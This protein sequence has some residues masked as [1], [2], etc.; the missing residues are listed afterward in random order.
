MRG[1]LQLIRS[2]V[3]K[4]HQFRQLRQSQRLSIAQFAA[5]LRRLTRSG[6]FG[7]TLDDNLRDQFVCGLNNDLIRQRLFVEEKLDYNRCLSITTALEAVERNTAVVDGSM[8]R[9]SSGVDGLHKLNVSQCVAC[10][11][12]GHQGVD[13]RF[14]SFMCRNCRKLGHLERD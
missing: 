12:S 6:E 7:D 2:V 3:A 13:Y 4:R 14:K 10:G 8:A 5:E 11:R 1:H 9:G